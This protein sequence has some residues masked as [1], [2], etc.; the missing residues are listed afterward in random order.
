MAAVWALIAMATE[1]SMATSE[2]HFLFSAKPSS[3]L[4]GNVRINPSSLEPTRK[5]SVDT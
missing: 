3:W 2:D 1:D 4:S 5:V